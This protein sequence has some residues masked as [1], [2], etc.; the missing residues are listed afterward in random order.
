MPDS[1]L[2]RA[3]RSAVRSTADVLRG[4]PLAVRKPNLRVSV[5]D[6]GFRAD[7]KPAPLRARP[8]S[9]RSRSTVETDH[10]PHRSKRRPSRDAGDMPQGWAEARDATGA[11]YYLKG[12]TK[13]M[14]KPT[15]EDDLRAE[16]VDQRAKMIAARR[17]A[18]ELRALVT[19]SEAAE[20]AAKR[21]AAEA[22]RTMRRHDAAEAS[23]RR[24][25]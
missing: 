10:R 3:F 5:D 21:E 17:E 20:A 11:T 8:A 4:S 16:L 22:E 14:G 19:T 25:R 15:V 2:K 12:K 18:E 6:R 1:P 13:Q 23:G 7:A 24:R 9:S